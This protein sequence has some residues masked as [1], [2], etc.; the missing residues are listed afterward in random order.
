MS[1]IGW[2][3]SGCLQILLRKLLIRLEFIDLN[4]VQNLSKPG[5]GQFLEHQFLAVLWEQQKSKCFHSY[6][7]GLLV[8]VSVVNLLHLSSVLDLQVFHPHQYVAFSMV[9]YTVTK[10]QGE[11]TEIVT[12][13]N[14]LVLKYMVCQ[15]KAV[16]II[17]KV[18][19]GK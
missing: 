7:I 12:Y 5:D 10:S 1:L 11:I 4:I 8:I 17:T 16:W 3:C 18:F 14:S 19:K 2:L 15:W 6:C 13:C 9:A